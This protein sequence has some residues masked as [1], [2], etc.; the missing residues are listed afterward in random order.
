MS[1]Y[2]VVFKQYNGHGKGKECNQC[3]NNP[4]NKDERN[5]E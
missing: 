2:C 1:W 5:V 4:A 3:R